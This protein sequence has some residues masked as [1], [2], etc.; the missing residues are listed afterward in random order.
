[1]R[2][3]NFSGMVLALLFFAILTAGCGKKAAETEQQGT[4]ADTG[5]LVIDSSPGLAEA[6]IGEEYKGDTP[7]TL[8]NLPVGSY[9]ITIKKEGYDDF[10]KTATIKAGRTAEIDAELTQIKPAEKEESK[11]PEKQAAE[12]ATA[13]HLKKVSLS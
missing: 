6:Y 11:E 5:A 3:K 7:V 8:Y 10:R 12:N 1:M 13:T 4:S 2:S 9:D